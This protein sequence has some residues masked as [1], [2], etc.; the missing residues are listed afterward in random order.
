M[1]LNRYLSLEIFFVHCGHGALFVA[2]LVIVALELPWW[3]LLVGM[4]LVVFSLGG[5]MYEARIILPIANRLWRD[6]SITTTT[7]NRK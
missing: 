7:K 2:V 1:N 4:P 6:E 3:A 5:W